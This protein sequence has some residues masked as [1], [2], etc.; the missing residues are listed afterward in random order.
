MGAPLRGARN[1]TQEGKVHPTE[2]MDNA[3]QSIYVSHREAE[4]RGR[5][6]D[7]ISS[8]EKAIADLCRQRRGSV[9]RTIEDLI[10]VR[11]V[12]ACTDVDI[13]VAEQGLRDTFKSCEAAAREVRRNV[14]R[15][16]NAEE[17][18]ATLRRTRRMVHLC[19]RIELMVTE[20]RLH[21]AVKLVNLYR[22]QREQMPNGGFLSSMLPEE[23]VL[24]K[25]IHMHA[26]RLLRSWNRLAR[27][28]AEKVGRYALLHDERAVNLRMQNRM[29]WL[30]QV[31]EER[32]GRLWKHSIMDT[33]QGV[34]SNLGLSTEGSPGRGPRDA[35]TS[36]SLPMRA[37]LCSFLVH[38]DLRREDELRREYTLERESALDAEL[39][40][41]RKDGDISLYQKA[42][43]SICG[44]FVIERTVA[45]HC[46]H[47]NS[48]LM[49]R[50][51]LNEL[52]SRAQNSVESMARR[53]HQTQG[54][55]VVVELQEMRE[56]LVEF[57][58]RYKFPLRTSDALP[59]LNE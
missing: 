19:A 7:Q 9:E 50:L 24:E 45:R 49:P 6:E 16:E 39:D 36:P 40:T 37:L 4:F 52:W 43:T 38:R 44:F 57:A 22:E 54:D 33:S 28:A 23:E 47:V 15:K 35:E 27:N 17:A 13:G 5:V 14:Q 58:G 53:L 32:H 20:R 2:A 34:Q 18:L 26:M 51:V 8:T 48:V 56:R 11:E 30:P 1:A 42:L 21:A 12:V 3:L 31:V 55:D 41:M 25:E 10:N 29:A 59:F 46:E